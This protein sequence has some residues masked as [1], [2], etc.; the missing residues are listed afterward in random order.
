MG[1]SFGRPV[2]P[3]ARWIAAAVL[4]LALAI[5]IAGCGGSGSET[6]SSQAA[7]TVSASTGLGEG[8]ELNFCSD[9]N[10]PPEEFME[11]TTPV[12][13]EIELADA[14]AERIGLT[15][16]FT[17]VGFD[18]IIAA[19][20][21]HKCD[22]VIS[23]MADT[24]ERR[25]QVEFVDYEKVGEAILVPAGNPLGIKSLADLGGKTVAVQNGTADAETLEEFNART[26]GPKISIQ[27]FEKDTDAV[28][29]LQAGRVD[30][31]FSDAPPVAYYAR[32]DPSNFEVTGGAIKVVP[33]GIAI[34]RGETQLHTALRKA[35]DGLVKDGTLTGYLDKW[36]LT[37]VSEPM[38]GES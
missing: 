11:G 15:A 26:S 14:A 30:A 6:Q 17:Q 9:M 7:G 19:L 35:I 32:Q 21:G 22:A 12:G 5:L 16:H 24:P 8:G 25:K 36:D 13:A 2:R 34:R 37:E 31:Y 33:W 3:Y 23:A 28:S 29:A 20:L 18:G 27:L 38:T 10:F 1:N 4:V